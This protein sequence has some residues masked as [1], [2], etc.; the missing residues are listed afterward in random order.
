MSSSRLSRTWGSMF[1]ISEVYLKLIENTGANT[2]FRP[3]RPMRLKR[4]P[5][6]WPCMD[7]LHAVAEELRGESARRSGRLRRAAPLLAVVAAALFA[8]AVL[9]SGGLAEALNR[10]ISADWRWVL[11]GV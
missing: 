1:C 4:G 8:L 10:A 2:S 7:S 3:R 11:A 6:R 5:R 9:R